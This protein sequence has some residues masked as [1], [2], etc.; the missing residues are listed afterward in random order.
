MKNNYNDL[1]DKAKT[2]EWNGDISGCL[3]NLY[4]AKLFTQNNDDRFE[5][6]MW[7]NRLTESVKFSRKEKD[8]K[9]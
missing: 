5:I 3:A 9:K 7:I 1:I 2:N 6:D 8:V 4:K